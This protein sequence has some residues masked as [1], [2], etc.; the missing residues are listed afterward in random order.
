MGNTQVSYKKT[1][2]LSEVL[3][4]EKKTWISD[5]ELFQKYFATPLSVGLLR[6]SEDFIHDS[7]PILR[8]ARTIESIIHITN[9]I[10]DV[11]HKYR[12][13]EIVTRR[14]INKIKD[15]FVEYAKV[16]DKTLLQTIDIWKPKFINKFPECNTLLSKLRKE[17]E[18]KEWEWE[19]PWYANLEM[20]L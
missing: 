13:E 20:R 15:N 2:S 9:S 5:E 3:L 14:F 16:H 10:T 19:E 12:F 1:D 11:E 6:R 7:Q 18:M 17:V 8:N 4:T